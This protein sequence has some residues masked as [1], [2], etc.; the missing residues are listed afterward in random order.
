MTETIEYTSS[1]IAL[2]IDREQFFT[3]LYERMFPA[4]ARFIRKQHG[5]MD[6]AKDIFHDALIIFYE[7]KVRGD[8]QISLTDEAYVFGIVKHLWIKRSQDRKNILISEAESFIN[9]PEDFDATPNTNFVI[10]FLKSSG[11]KCMGLLQAFYYE[12]RSLD[13]IKSTFGFA[14]IRSATVQKFKC[15]EKV[16]DLVKNKSKRYED[17]FE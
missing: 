10:A 2:E 16:R 11:E 7:K 17:F 13:Q 8:F 5:S 6:D 12:K 3:G 15:L 1:S 4:V 9:I 14:S